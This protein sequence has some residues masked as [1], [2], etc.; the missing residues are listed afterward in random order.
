MPPKRQ[1]IE[2]ADRR[3]PDLIVGGRTLH[4]DTYDCA[5]KISQALANDQMVAGGSEWCQKVMGRALEL[6]RSEPPPDVQHV[7]LNERNPDYP[8]PP[9][10]DE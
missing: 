4:A 9:S 1:C 6:Q 5:S 8:W 10:P 7:P 3:C 2:G